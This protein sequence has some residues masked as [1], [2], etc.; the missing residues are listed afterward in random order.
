MNFKKILLLLLALVM[1]L[2]I[3]A[4]GNTPADS[5]DPVGTDPVDTDPAD[6]VETVT[7]AEAL[8]LC[9]DVGNITSERYYIRATVK[10]VSN[11][12]YGSMVIYDET[13]EISVYGTYSADGELK[14]SELAERPLKG[15]EVLL[16]CILQNYNG[17]KEVKNARLISF[18]S[19]QGNFD[20]A[21][22]K[23]ATVAEAR[24]AE[25]GAKV[26]VSGVVARI[27]YANGMKPSGFILV[28]GADSIYVY[29]TDAAAA[30]SIGN[31][32]EVAAS[33]TYWILDSE[34]GAAA[35]HGYRG[36][37]QLEDATVVSNDK[38]QNEWITAAIPE[39]TVKN[40][41]DTPVTED[42]TTKIYKVTALVKKAPGNGFTNYYI[43]DLDEKTGSYVYT[44]CNGSDFSWLDEFDGKICTVYLMAL[45]AKSTQAGCVYRFLPVSVT[46]GAYVSSAPEDIA[47]HAVIYYGAD[48]FEKLYT[49]DPALELVT[50]VSSNLLWFQNATLTY[51]S[52]NESVV[53]IVNEDGKTVMHCLTSGEATVTV[54]GEYKGASYTKDVVVKVSISENIPSIKVGDAIASAVG[55]VVTVKGI[56]GPS[57]VNQTGFYLIDETGVIPVVLS[58]AEIE[59]VQ[60][61]NEVIIR[62][63]R[64]TRI[65]ENVSCFGQTNLD[66]CEVVANNYGSH[67]YSTASFI[68]GKTAADFYAL[69]ANEDHGTEVYVFKATIKVV[70]SQYYSQI[71]VTSGSTEIMLYCS[72]ANQYSWLKAY[73][74][75]EVT[76][77]IAPCNWNS[78]G[79]Y[80]GC[81]LAVRNADGTKVCNELNFSK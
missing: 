39:T 38:G 52:S 18:V 54:K 48:Q 63:T 37:N 4:C 36:C 80:R 13:G 68:E 44:Q 51:T 1:A 73:A 41:I 15:D 66:A 59:K 21:D 43:N 30:V 2:S 75:Q 10:T 40:I 60:L 56:V 20:V 42:I 17:T 50:S 11:A 78:L 58:K 77:E 14:Y 31:R 23:S 9:G 6:E 32:V 33:K 71:F 57:L 25:A 72:S 47:E 64:D 3:V 46:A 69:S 24:A 81:V 34:Q 28:D 55:E 70:Y 22:Y 35:T 67:A 12:E 61:G 49:G 26:K 19:N 45:N 27:T 29:G 65:K 7:I 5:T 79:N 74:G 16:H 76:V 53:K 62:G 8:E